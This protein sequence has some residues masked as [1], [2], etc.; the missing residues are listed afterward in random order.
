MNEHRLTDLSYEQWIDHVFDHAVPFYEQPWYFDVDADWWD[1]RP[2]QAVAYLTRL[3][4][5][6]EPLVEEF[7]DDQIGQGLYYLVSNSGSG[8]CQC[9]TDFSVPI[10]ARVVCIAAMRT[11]FA[12]LF[13]SRCPRILSHLDEPG[14]NQL[15]SICYMW[16]DIVPLGSVSKPGTPDPIDDACLNVM[17]ETLKLS[18]PACQ[19]NALHGLGHWAH[20]YPEFTAASIDGYLAANPNLRPELVNY[21]KAARAGCIQ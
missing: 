11:L 19:E 6:P 4:E 13:E 5:S 14:S 9:L 10:A 20:A 8:C 2:E 16:W 21:A 3:F 15:S 18:N 17:R 7:A 12:K 1:P